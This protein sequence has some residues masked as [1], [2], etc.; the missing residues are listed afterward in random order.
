MA[1]LAVG[2]RFYYALITLAALCSTRVPHLRHWARFGKMRFGAGAHG[3]AEPHLMRRLD[4]TV[5]KRYFAHFYALGALWNGALLGTC[6][7]RG[8]AWACAGGLGV[9]A[10]LCLALAELHLL[11][12]L[13]ECVSLE[14]RRGSRMHVLSYALGLSYYAAL[15]LA[16]LCGGGGGVGNGSILRRAA[17]GA[18]FAWGS[19]HQHRCHAALA[20]LRMT[21][22]APRYRVPRGGWFEVCSCA[23]YTAE[24]VLYVGLVIVHGAREPT[25]WMLLLWVVV[26][27][28]VN[29]ARSHDW[30][31]RTF[32]A[33]YPQ[34]RFA[35]LPG[36][37]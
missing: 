29:G 7:A 9:D 3:G 36:V 34:G 37:L 1:S 14:Q 16:L 18:L 23:H 27:L 15:P 24:M 30:Y 19:W 33:A 32:G 13:Y 12:R 25:V 2:L 21:A 10:A 4:V 6:A 26:G 22:D 35:V 28:S 8:S 17:G 20:S 31:L 5:P 11:R